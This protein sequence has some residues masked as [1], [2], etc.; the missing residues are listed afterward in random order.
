MSR[1]PE[2]FHNA[3]VGDLLRRGEPSPRQVW[4][5]SIDEEAPHI[6]GIMYGSNLANTP[7]KIKVT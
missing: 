2:S 4:S 1:T 7:M 6:T 5:A 3:D